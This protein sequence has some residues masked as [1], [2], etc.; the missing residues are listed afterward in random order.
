MLSIIVKLLT[1]VEHEIYKRF[2]SYYIEVLDSVKTQVLISA[3]TAHTIISTII[4]S[5]LKYINCVIY[6]LIL[7]LMLNK[8]HISSKEFCFKIKDMLL[9]ILLCFVHNCHA[10]LM[11]LAYAFFLYIVNLCY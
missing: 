9:F 3:C 8:T 1:W 10:E 11:C 7:R 5:S 6:L 2:H 4:A